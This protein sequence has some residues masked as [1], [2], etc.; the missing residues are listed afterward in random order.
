M[1]TGLRAVGQNLPISRILGQL[2][3]SPHIVPY[4]PTRPDGAS[5]RTVAPAAELGALIVAKA[6]GEANFTVK[7]KWSR[8]RACMA[9]AAWLAVSPSLNF[10][11]KA[12]VNE[13][14]ARIPWTGPYTVVPASPL[15]N[16]W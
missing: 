6:Q 7:L 12:A 13:L 5:P 2:P 8:H 10:H 11:A 3:I 14:H 16:I 15:L 4:E 9:P 1:F